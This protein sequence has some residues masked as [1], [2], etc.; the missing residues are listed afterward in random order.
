MLIKNLFKNYNSN[1]NTKSINNLSIFY[2]YNYKSINYI[3]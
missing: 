3:L 1:K 2:N